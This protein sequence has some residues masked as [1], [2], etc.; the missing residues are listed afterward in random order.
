MENFDLSIYCSTFLKDKSL[1]ELVFF[2]DQN[3]SYSYKDLML[4]VLLQAE[5]NTDSFSALKIKSSYQ[6]F[7]HLLAA[8]MTKKSVLIISDKEPEAAV[9]D[10]QKQL[11]FVN[12]ISDGEIKQSATSSF[13]NYT[14]DMQRPAFYILSSG[15]SGPS[16]SIGLSL[17]NVYHSAKSII[18][19]F[20][21]R[22][23]DCTFL[24]IPHQHIGGLMIL[25]R[26]FFSQSS[27]TV[28]EADNYQFI[29]L[30]PL[31]LKRSLQAPDKLS[32]LQNCRG[33]LIGG[34]PLDA[35]LKKAGLAQKIPLYETYGM[36]ETTSLVM[37]NGVALEGQTVKL[38]SEN[39]FLIKGPT[40]S[41]QVTLDQNGFYHTK[42]IGEKNANGSYSFKQRSDVLFKSAGEL[43][44]PLLIEEK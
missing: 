17:N 44:D 18:D 2:K 34:A 21:M 36:S 41:S 19:F 42:D 26:A 4:S 12:V 5:Q 13:F 24:N 3:E 39:Y 23:S 32:K 7:I 27:V 28:N 8:N 38:D 35:E 31:Q 30:V 43:I 9:L 29:S 14:I 20:S 37:L 33:V 6:L 10:Y 11:N 22:S 15:S 1:G 16:K 25:W 40:L